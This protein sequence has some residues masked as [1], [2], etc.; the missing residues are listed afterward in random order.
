M[1]KFG[2]GDLITLAKSGWTPE[3]FN[4]A[5]DRIEALAAKESNDNSGAEGADI[6]DESNEA[7]LKTDETGAEGADVPEES[8]DKDAKIAELE[9]QLAEAQKHNRQQNNDSGEQKSLDEMVD[10]IFKDYFD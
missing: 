10:D 7:D 6:P 8:D 1:A 2:F 9:K 4:N 5:M 3:A